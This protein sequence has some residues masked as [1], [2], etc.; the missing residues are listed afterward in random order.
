MS[1]AALTLLLAHVAIAGITRQTDEG[2]P[3]RLFQ[4]LMI[5]Q[6]PVAAHFALK[7]LPRRPLHALQVLLLQACTGLAAVG[8]VAWFER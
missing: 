2:V 1:V 4:L 5:L 3:A 6:L 8:A 7:W